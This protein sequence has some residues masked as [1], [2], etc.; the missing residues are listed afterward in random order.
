MERNPYAPPSTAVADIT[1]VPLTVN[2]EVLLA[3]KVFWVAFSVSC[4]N[5]VM[6]ILGIATIAPLPG[7]LPGALLG[8]AFSF[9]ITRW[10]NSKLKAGRNW[11]RLF[12]TAGAV[13]GFLSIA[14]LWRVYSS[15]ILPMY[16][17][18]PIN[19]AFGVLGTAINTWGV[20][21]LNLPNS[22]AWFAARSERLDGSKQSQTVGAAMSTPVICVFLGLLSL[23][24][25]SLLYEFRAEHTFYIWVA[26]TVTVVLLSVGAV[27]GIRQGVWR[28]EGLE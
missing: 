2:R 19:A 16:A 7:G 26:G 15:R 12:V 11:M 9:V 3:C 10:V 14:I 24:V 13:L 17:K 1:S 20:V 18:S 22:R 5:R 23:L 21:L 6:H 4:V 8:M 27:V 25:T 28:S